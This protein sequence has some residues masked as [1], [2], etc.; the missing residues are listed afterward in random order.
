MS[1]TAASSASHQHMHL[2]T[3]CL[4]SSVEIPAFISTPFNLISSS[5]QPHFAITNI[6]MTRRLLELP[7]SVPEPLALHPTRRFT[8]VSRRHHPLP[9][10]PS[11][12][13]P[14]CHTPSCHTPSCHTCLPFSPSSFSSIFFWRSC[15]T[16]LADLSANRCRC[17]TSRSRSVRFAF[18]IPPRYPSRSS[19]HSTASVIK[20]L[21]ASTYL[22]VVTKLVSSFTVAGLSICFRNNEAHTSRFDH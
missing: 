18:S 20:L 3:S 11:C 12:H 5:F 14:S 19:L 17:L 13:T 4:V 21:A 8:R 6:E 16:L 10:F 22:L 2:T 7:R 1:P 9:S 15:Q